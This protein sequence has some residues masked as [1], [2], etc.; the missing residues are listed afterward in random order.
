MIGMAV[1]GCGRIGRMHAGVLARHPAVRLAAVFDIVPEAAA[2]TASELGVPAAPSVEAVLAMPAVRAVLIATPTPTHVPLIEAAARAGRAILCEKPIDLDTARATACRDRIA[3]L[4]PTVMI[5]FNRRFDPSFRALRERLAAGE[6]GALEQLSIISRDPAPPPAEYVAGSGGLFRDMAIHDFDMARA[7]AGEIVEVFAAGANL[8]EPAI[9]AAGDIDAAM[10]TLRARSGALVH[11]SNSRRC[12]FGYDQRIEAF[13]AG[14][15]LQALNRQA[16]T[17]RAW[18]DA[19]GDAG[20]PALHFFIERYAEAYAAEI[21][22]FVRCVETG[23][24]PSP[25]FDDGLQ[26]LRLADAAEQS[27]RSGRAVRLDAA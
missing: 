27:L 20:D 16:T 12:A 9:Q 23:A 4:D 8:I 6:I 10:L 21:D 3:P 5:G 14:G 7:L 25:S 24:A 17:V 11:I 1:L 2:R 19:R 15:M 26:A 18:T 13:G 22:F